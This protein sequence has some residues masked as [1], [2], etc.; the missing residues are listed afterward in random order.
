MDFSGLIEQFDERPHVRGKQFERLCR[1]LLLNAAVRTY[2]HL[3]DE[4]L[5]DAEFMDDAVR[6]R[7]ISRGGAGA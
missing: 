2:V 6:G 3:T 4:G 1:W 5:G 7:V